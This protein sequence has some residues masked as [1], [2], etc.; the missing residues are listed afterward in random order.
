MSKDNRYL[1]AAL[2]HDSRLI[3]AVVRSRNY[4]RPNAQK[5][6]VFAA[7][8]IIPGEDPREYQELLIELMDEWKPS[9]PTL[10]EG[11]VDLVDWMWKR[12]RLRKFIQTQLIRGMFHPSTPAFNEAWGFIRFTYYLRTEPET[13][14]EKSANKCLRAD[15]INYLKQKFP[16]SNYQSTLEWVEAITKEIFSVLIPAE[17]QMME[18]LRQWKADCQVAG[19]ILQAVELLDYEFKQSELLEARIARKAKSLFEL[20]TMEQM[21]GRT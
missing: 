14:F 15:K 8:A 19:T 5:A 7:A 16:R 18:A 11:I 2:K 9:G 3:N 1:P 17:E 4:K 6:G 10:R 21:L 13:C 20:K 12:R